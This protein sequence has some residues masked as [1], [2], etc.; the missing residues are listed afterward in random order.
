[1]LR[2]CSLFLFLLSTTA[3]ALAHP[4]HGAL[5]IHWHLDD[6]VWAAIGA[7]ALVGIVLLVRKALKR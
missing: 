1:M 2:S 5:E 6:I 4:G 3:S 7:F